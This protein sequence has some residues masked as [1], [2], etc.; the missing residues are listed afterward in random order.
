MAAQGKSSDPLANRII[1]QIEARGY[2]VSLHRMDGGISL[3]GRSLPVPD[4]Y[5]EI[6][7]HD[8]ADPPQVFMSR[9]DDHGDDAEY[10]AAALLAQS[11]G[12]EVWE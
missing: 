10:T 2:H 7:A 1:R 9:V 3:S 12:I 6:H 11:V 4:R 5:V 8:F